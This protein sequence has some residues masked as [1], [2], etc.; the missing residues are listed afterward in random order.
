MREIFDE[1]SI[2]QIKDATKHC[3]FNYG[4][5]TPYCRI[6]PY[7]IYGKC[8]TRILRLDIIKLINRVIPDRLEE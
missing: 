7:N 2:E 6:C 8:C 1:L 5:C 3:T 4:Q